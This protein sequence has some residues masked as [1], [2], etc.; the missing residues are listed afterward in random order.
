V[1]WTV[2]FRRAARIVGIASAVTIAMIATVTAISSN[3]KPRFARIEPIPSKHRAAAATREARGNAAVPA[4]AGA[5][6]ARNVAG[7]KEFACGGRSHRAA[8]PFQRRSRRVK[9]AAATAT[10]PVA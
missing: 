1:A 8:P 6:R 7:W 5:P 10:T 2:A 9:T 3:V 4:R